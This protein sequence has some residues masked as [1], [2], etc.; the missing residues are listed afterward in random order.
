M[1]QPTITVI[2]GDQRLIVTATELAAGG[3]SVCCYLT[4]ETTLKKADSLQEAMEQA[5]IVLLPLPLSNDDK[6]IQTM[7][8]TLPFYELLR[9]HKPLFLGGKA[10]PNFL[11][12]ARDNNCRFQDYFL[13]EELNIYNAIPTAEG[14]IAIAMKEL[15]ITLSQANCLVT[16]FGRIG[17]LLA[18]RLKGMGANVTCTARKPADLAWIDAFGYQKLPTREIQKA[19][20]DY[21][22][23]FNTVPT[24]LFP[25]EVLH[26]TKQDVL[27]IDLASKPGGV[28][29][30]A[31]KDLK[32]KAIHA[33]SL[34]GKVAPLTAGIIIKD[35][36][37]HLLQEQNIIE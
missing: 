13:R 29:F 3:Y 19:L 7:E 14:A 20:S 1:M 12:E 2:G 6:T 37:L 31:A 9:Y 11:Q 21:D 35:T 34:P 15:P 25:K 30:N 22:V 32:R 36:V 16:G 8:G 10:G 5:D 23:I 28:D 33:L 26:Q 27:L 18:H 4:A 17:K 24:M